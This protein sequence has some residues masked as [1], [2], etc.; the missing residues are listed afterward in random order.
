MLSAP[1]PAVR[2][3]PPPT[4]AQPTLGAA[5]TP[6]VPSTS[7]IVLGLTPL[8]LAA[9]VAGGR[10]TVHRHLRSRSV[11]AIVTEQYV[12]HYH[13]PRRLPDGDRAWLLRARGFPP[14]SLSAIVAE[15]QGHRV[16]ASL[17]TDSGDLAGFVAFDV[18]ALGRLVWRAAR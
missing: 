18:V 9:S 4:C 7:T 6:A 8:E 15:C 12:A 10:G 1:R 11:E 2:R 16:A 14:V 3:W 17:Y 5:T 13:V